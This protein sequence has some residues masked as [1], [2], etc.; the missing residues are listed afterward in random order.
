MRAFVLGECDWVCMCYAGV[1]ITE[2]HGEREK[3]VLV[4]NVDELTMTWKVNADI[5][6]KLDWS[7]GG[8]ENV[9]TLVGGDSKRIL[10]W[11]P[12]TRHVLFDDDHLVWIT[13]V[14]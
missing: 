3:V 13:Q 5:E 11:R 7:W 12:T 2:R 1:W 8:H 10:R 6:R 14:E 9:F 4:G